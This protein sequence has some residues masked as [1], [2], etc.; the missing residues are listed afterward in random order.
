[1]NDTRKRMKVLCP[2]NR[3]GKTFWM[4]VGSAFVNADGSISV[5]LDAYPT[6]R[7]LVIRD[8]EATEQT[9]ETPS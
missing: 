6:D 1:M 3:N 8:L 4:R 2:L 7:K 9:T 5:Y